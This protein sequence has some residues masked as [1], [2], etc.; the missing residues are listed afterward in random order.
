M[1]TGMAPGVPVT[2]TKAPREEAK[3]IAG[4]YVP[5]ELCSLEPVCFANG[6]ESVDPVASPRR[7]NLVAG[8]HLL[9][10]GQVG[11]G[12][13]VLRS[14]SIR[15]YALSRDGSERTTDLYLRGEPIGLDAFGVSR[16]REYFVAL[17]PSTYCD[18]SLPA[19]RRLMSEKPE[20]REAVMGLM[21]Q[22]LGAARERLPALRQG[23]ARARLAAFLLDLYERRESRGL[24]VDHFRLTLDRGEIASLLGLTLETVSRSMGQ[25][26]RAGVIRV[27]GKHLSILDPAALAAEADGA[28]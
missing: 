24:P 23:P 6:A 20:V 14:G 16:Q 1:F 26:Q 15:S 5:C 8:Q 21:G 17:E 13:Q 11:R 2:R 7:R 12:V 22:A 27:S 4:D 18:V 19:I 9:Y 3:E 10:A 25:L 28:S